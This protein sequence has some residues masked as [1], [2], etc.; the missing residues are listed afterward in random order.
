M[1]Y[2]YLT[3]S[4]E[5]LNAPVNILWGIISLENARGP[6]L[7]NV[8][9]SI[10]KI[11]A[12][13]LLLLTYGIMSPYAAIAIGVTIFSKSALLMAR[14]CRYH[15]MQFSGLLDKGCV[16]RD[17]YHLDLICE[18][19]HSSIHVMVWPGTLISA[20]LFG[21]YMFDMANDTSEINEG[22]AISAFVLTLLVVPLLYAAFYTEKAKLDRQMEKNLACEIDLPAINNPMH[23]GDGISATITTTN[24]K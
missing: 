15:H 8:G 11:W 14:I 22:L 6:I 4:I 3:Y 9:Y 16:K 13:L 24:G 1:L 23:N 2:F 18:M 19:T 21:L 5:D 7:S 12:T 17:V 10:N 20:I